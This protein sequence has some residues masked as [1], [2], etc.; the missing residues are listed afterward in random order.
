MQENVSLWAWFHLLQ[1]CFNCLDVCSLLYCHVLICV[2]YFYIYKNKFVL[3]LPEKVP[4]SYFKTASFFTDRHLKNPETFSLGLQ[5]TVIF[6]IDLICCHHKLPELKV[7]SSIVCFVW[8]TVQNPKIFKWNRE[9]QKKKNAHFWKAETREGKFCFM[10]DQNCC[11]KKSNWLIV[12]VLI[13]LKMTLK[14]LL[15]FPVNQLFNTSL[16][17]SCYVEAR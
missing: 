4:K 17:H 8:L 15:S 13:Q 7:R 14:Q 16:Y 1:K 11:K 5:L 9:K 2:F 12:S 3:K 6:I 10:N